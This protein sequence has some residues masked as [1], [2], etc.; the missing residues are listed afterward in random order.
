MFISVPL[1]DL[2]L[3]EMISEEQEQFKKTPTSASGIACTHFL[4]Q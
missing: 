2:T 4:S 1:T 3:N